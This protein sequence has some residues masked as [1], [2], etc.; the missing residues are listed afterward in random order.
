MN[1]V[2]PIF[3]CG[4]LRSGSTLFHL[5]LNSHPNMS[6]PGEFDFLFDRIS[7]TGAFPSVQSYIEYLSSNRIFN[8]KKLIVD[9]SLSYPELIQSFIRQ[10]AEKNK[11]F[12]L[13]VHRNFDH[14]HLLYPDAKYIHL[15]RDPRDV[16]RSSIGMKWAGNV[17]YGVN[18]WIN[19]EKSWDRL[20]LK[21]NKEQYLDIKFED[22]ISDTKSTLMKVCEFIGV[23]FSDEIFNY[24]Q[25]STYGKPDTSLIN[26]WQRKLSSRELQNVESK[27]VDMMRERNYKLSNNPIKEPSSFE[28]F[29]LGIQNKIYIIT[30]GIE[31]YG[32]FLYSFYRLSSKLG[33]NSWHNSLLIKVNE[34]NKTHLK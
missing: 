12:S 7:D 11:F 22:L 13:N 6:N 15:L 9:D 4:A 29:L 27:V 10:K 1:K 32:F 28:R 14:A 19:T 33:I 17:Y 3:I 34:I 26:Q 2:C 18:H 31:R 8:S 24:Q 16:A 20:K 23:E 30:K 5:M 21:L 25:S